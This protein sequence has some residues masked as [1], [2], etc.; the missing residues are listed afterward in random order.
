MKAV[1][2]RTVAGGAQGGPGVYAMVAAVRGKTSR[3]VAAAIRVISCARIGLIAGSWSSSSWPRM[4]AAVRDHRPP[5]LRDSA[6]I[7]S[8]RVNRASP[9]QDDERQVILR[10]AG[11]PVVLKAAVP[12]DRH[13]QRAR[14]RRPDSRVDA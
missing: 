14:G 2:R 5:A 13:F 6:A 3:T 1:A 7:D 11:L 10:P 4:N 9:A 12:G 8:M